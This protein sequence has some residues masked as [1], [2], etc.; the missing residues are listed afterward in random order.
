MHAPGGIASLVMAN[1]RLAA[2]GEL[3]RLLAAYLALG[4]AAAVVALARRR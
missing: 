2:H 4:A 3:R 1:L